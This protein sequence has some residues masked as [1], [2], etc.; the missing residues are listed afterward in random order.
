MRRRIFFVL[1][2]FVSIGAQAQIEPDYGLRRGYRG[3][4]DVGYTFGVG[5]FDFDRV[6]LSTSHGYQIFPYL[7]AGL[8]AGVQFYTGDGDASLEFPLFVHLRGSLPCHRIVQP[9]IDWKIG[10][11]VGDSDGFYMAPAV[12]CRFA[13]SELCGLSLSIG[14]TLQDFK[15]YWGHYTVWKNYGGLSLKVGFDF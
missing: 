1:L 2:L 5:T 8:G 15:I 11:T 7:F 6:E 3:F 14:Y 10:Y 12:G 4:V 13:M 9:F